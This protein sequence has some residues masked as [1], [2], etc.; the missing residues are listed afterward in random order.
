MNSSNWSP[1]RT[2]G[3]KE[4]EVRVTK[5][6]RCYTVTIIRTNYS[7]IVDASYKLGGWISNTIEFCQGWEGPDR[8]SEGGFIFHCSLCCQFMNPTSSLFFPPPFLSY[9]TCLQPKVKN[10]FSFSSHAIGYIRSNITEMG[11]YAR[12]RKHGFVQRMAQILEVPFPP[13]PRRSTLSRVVIVDT[14][15]DQSES[16]QVGIEPRSRRK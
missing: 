4:L 12:P 6:V 16:V 9:S 13:L 3:Y 8:R 1:T 14:T 15:P 5:S 2:V 11:F 10:C 7:V